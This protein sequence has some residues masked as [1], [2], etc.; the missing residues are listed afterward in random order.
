MLTDTHDATIWLPVK[1]PPPA[2]C[3][4]QVKDPIS[5][6]TLLIDVEH[7]AWLQ[8]VLGSRSTNVGFRASVDRSLHIRVVEP[9]CWHLLQQFSPALLLPCCR[10]LHVFLKVHLLRPVFLLQH[11]L[12]HP[13][14]L[15]RLAQIVGLLLQEQLLLHIM[16]L[17][18]HDLLGE[19]LA[20]HHLLL[21]GLLVDLV[22]DLSLLRFSGLV[23]VLRLPLLLL[24]QQLLALPHLLL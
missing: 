3:Q 19:I 2:I 7:L 10:M 13:L 12:V 4:P 16:L 1:Q 18:S 9:L 24:H 5:T 20:Q 15:K 23:N 6:F 8:L 14:H 11:V 22:Q 17:Q 21:S